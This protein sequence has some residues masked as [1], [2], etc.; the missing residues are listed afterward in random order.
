MPTT[1]GTVYALAQTMPTP[2]LGSLARFLLRE[3][4]MGPIPNARHFWK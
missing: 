2:P 3:A 1:Y 4:A